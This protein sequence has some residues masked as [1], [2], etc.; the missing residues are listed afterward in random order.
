VT[1]WWVKQWTLLS[2]FMTAYPNN[3]WLIAR[4]IKELM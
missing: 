1:F 3:R 2:G 4:G